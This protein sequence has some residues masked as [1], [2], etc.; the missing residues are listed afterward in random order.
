MGIFDRIGKV[1]KANVNSALDKVEDPEKILEQDIKDMEEQYSK[2]KKSV[3]SAKAQEM[4][5]GKKIDILED[6]VEKWLS[7]AK[8]A[9]NKGDE[10]L[11]K[12]ALEKKV[13]Y[14]KEL[15]TLK[16]DKASMEGHTTKLV[17]DLRDMEGRISEAKRKKD[18]VK[19]RLETAKAKKKMMETKAS[20]D[21]I[22]NGAFDSFNKMEEKANKMIDEVEAMEE[23]NESLAKDDLDKEFEKLE[24]QGA[25]DLE[26]E[27][28]KK[29][30]SGN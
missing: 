25:M 6:E 8:L 15:V 4:S 27:K 14:E 11:A 5:L 2:A 12:K 13:E 28:L 21:G 30:M 10:D 1:F 24:K 22:G 29:E 26:L 3:A 20:V 16:E 23:I 7:N 18:L 9:L 19:S 17:E